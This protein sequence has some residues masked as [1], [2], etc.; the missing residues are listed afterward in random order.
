MSS[1]AADLR[2]LEIPGVATF[3]DTAS[4][5]VRLDIATSLATAEIWLQGAHIARY[6]P[7]GCAPV[8][9]LSASSL[10]APGKAIRGGV[11]VIFPWFGPRAG[12]PE[13]PAHGF[14]RTMPWHIESLSCA[15]G[16]SLSLTLRLDSD[17]ATRALWPHDFIL[18]HRIAIGAHLGMTL[19]VTN[20]SAA[21]FQFEEALH[22]YLAVA[23]VR[24]AS[25]SGLE[26]VTYIDKVDRLARKTQDAAPIRITGETDRV[27]LD[28][29]ATC[30]LT[31]PGLTRR[32]TVETSG[33]RSTVLW[34]PWVA[35]AHA[36]ADFGDDEW[37]GMICIETA[38]AA[39]NAL[40]LAP[41][42]THTMRAAVRV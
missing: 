29:A 38:N 20:T 31:D 14:A 34:N 33:S 37:P 15:D 28:T 35:K 7:A 30:I 25:V 36:M 8:L 1:T 10:F 9:F 3:S 6:Q 23:D 19:G 2:H 22:T 18:R 39:D 12:H 32:V 5:L 40:T 13:S 17:D 26:G 27:Y 4:G 16:A 24:Q 41:A 42:A 11:P 21:P